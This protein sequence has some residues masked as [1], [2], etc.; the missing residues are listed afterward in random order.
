MIYQ[1]D[2]EFGPDIN[3][4]GCYFLSL[5]W[6][7]DRVFSLGIMDHK[8]INAIYANEQADYDIGPECF[9]QN[10]QGICDHVAPHRV[11]FM[12]KYEAQPNLTHNSSFEVQ[13]WFNPE[14]EYR[15]FVAG[16]GKNVIYDP[17]SAEGSRTVREGHLESRR[18]FAII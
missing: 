1:T 8:T 18:I 17:Y 15:H 12:G 7:L 9:L 10:P 3:H 5:L 2:E 11:G 16:D 14:T 13:C 6:Q 4:F